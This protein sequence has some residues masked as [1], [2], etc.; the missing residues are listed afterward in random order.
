[1][2]GCSPGKV[3]A[4]GAGG[5]PSQAAPRPYVAATRTLYF[6]AQEALLGTLGEQARGCLDH[7][8]PHWP[9]LGHLVHHH[10]VHATRPPPTDSKVRSAA[11][12]VPGM[13]HPKGMSERKRAPGA[14]AGTGKGAAVMGTQG[15]PEAVN[16]CSPGPGA[17][18]PTE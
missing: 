2:G 9:P 12:T 1:M 16:M 3:C 18:S 14:G 5:W 10:L 6:T 11:S 4:E 15:R 7:P 8:G 17:I 13:R